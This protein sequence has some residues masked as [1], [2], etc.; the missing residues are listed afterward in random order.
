MDTDPAEDARA[1]VAERFPQAVWAV[2]TGSVMTAARTA[3]S[4]LDIVVLVP[5]GDPAAPCRDTLHFRRWPVELFIHDAETLPHYIEREL[6]SGKPSLCRMVATGT[7]V[8]GDPAE[9]ISRCAALLAAGPGPLT[10]AEIERERYVLT[11][12]IDDLESAADPGERVVIAG[13]GWISAGTAALRLGDHWV[14]RGKWLLRELRDM[15]PALAAD[16]LGAAGD[17]EAIVAFARRVLEPVGGELYDGYRALGE[18][19]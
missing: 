5:D 14:G 15:D 7:P 16:W 13:A 6:P 8:A 4:D 11:D 17:P 9:W 2:V 3:G 19:P 18:R 1:L 10:T 12:L